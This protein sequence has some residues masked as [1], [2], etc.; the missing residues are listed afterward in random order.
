MVAVMLGIALAVALPV[1]HAAHL[2][3]NDTV[4]AQITLTHDANWEFGV[5]SNGTLFDAYQA[6]ST[7]NPGEAVTFSGT[8][9]VNTP[10]NPDPG[11]GI[12][13][14]VEPD[15]PNSVSDIIYAHWSTL[16][17]TPY[18]T[19][20]INIDVTSSPC[21]MGLGTLPA[22]FAGMGVVE[23]G[24]LFGIG[25]LFRDPNTA[26]LVTIPSN[27]G[28]TF[29]SDICVDIDIDIKPTS[30]PNPLNRKSKGVLPV[31]ILG[32]QDFDVAT[33]DPLTIKLSLGGNGDVAP[34]RYDFDDVATPYEGDE[35]EC[36]DLGPD[37]YMDLTLKFSTQELVGLDLSSYEVGD[38][39]PLI[40]TGNL[41]DSTSIIG[42]DCV[43]I[44]K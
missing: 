40:L 29:G 44:V 35:C 10:G 43:L 41:R 27:L 23:T 12:I 32:T 17:G 11:E 1:A 30:C 20:T 36:H 15:D 16:L 42:Q 19:A 37:G 18:G 33:I 21:Y 6:G 38:V 2:T 3:I 25:G 13:Y 31:A 34:L 39:V 28:I 5:N 22:A 9:Y 7:I 24:E 4:E 8:W 14:V 26:A